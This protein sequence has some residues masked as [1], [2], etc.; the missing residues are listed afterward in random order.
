MTDR[1]PPPAHADMSPRPR[2]LAHQIAA[3][4]RA[5]ENVGQY[6]R[7]AIDASIRSRSPAEKL[8]PTKADSRE[9][10]THVSKLGG[11]AK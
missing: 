4:E 10:Q 5:R 3:A 11:V 1:R 2:L 8:Y 9:P 7:E 6:L